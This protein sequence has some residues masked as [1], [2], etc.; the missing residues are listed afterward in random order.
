[1]DKAL[2]SVGRELNTKPKALLCYHTQ[3]SPAPALLYVVKVSPQ[4]KAV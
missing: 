3:L 1:M 2:G 4:M